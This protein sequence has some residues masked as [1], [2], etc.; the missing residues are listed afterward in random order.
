MAE[1]AAAAG[2]AFVSLDWFGDLDHSLLGP[3]FS[4]RR[5][6]PGFPEWRGTKIDRLVE[7]GIMLAKQERCDSVVYASGLENWPALL[8]RLLS[9]SGCRLYGNSPS[10]LQQVRDPLALCRGL[11]QAGFK[12]AET[13][14]PDSGL[15]AGNRRWLVK[16][17]KSGGGHGVAFAGKAEAVSANSV[18]Q[19]YLSGRPCSFTFVA[20]GDNSLVLGTTEQLVGSKS[21]TGRAFGYAGNLFPLPCGDPAK[22]LET[23]SRIARWLTSCY[24]LRGLN[25]VDFVLHDQ[26]V[27]VIEVNPRYSASMELLERAYELPMIELHLLACCG[28]WQKVKQMVEALPVKYPPVQPGRIWGKRVIYTA[29]RKLVRPIFCG[30]KEEEARAWARRMHARGFR[31]LPFPGDVI[32]GRNPVATVI[33]SGTT[34]ANCLKKLNSLSRLMRSQL[35]SC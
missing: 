9:E 12:A 3:L 13:C 15:P 24:G 23:V 31:D 30:E 20:D 16:P 35:C 27:W 28:N 2:Y 8:S 7:W 6:L 21:S 33:A 4:P 26:D 17:V 19:E 14:H 1:S 29:A 32:S 22:L 11:R 18:Y 5:P 25:G 34:R 10:V